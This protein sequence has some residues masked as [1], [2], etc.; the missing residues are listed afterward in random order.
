MTDNPYYARATSVEYL[1]EGADNPLN[2]DIKHSKMNNYYQ[3]LRIN[4]LGQ[5]DSYLSDIPN[6]GYSISYLWYRWSYPKY[7]TD[8]GYQPRTEKNRVRCVRKAD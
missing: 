4:G 5:S 8:A 1:G 6:D 2:Y 7:S 3:V